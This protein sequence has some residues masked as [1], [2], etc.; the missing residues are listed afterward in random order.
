MPQLLDN[1]N[2]TITV[3]EAA[4]DAGVSRRAIEHARDTG[5]IESVTIRNTRRLS[6]RSYRLWLQRVGKH[7][8]TRESACGDPAD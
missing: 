8:P 5:Q 7:P 3:K 4:E 2:L 6:R 1:N